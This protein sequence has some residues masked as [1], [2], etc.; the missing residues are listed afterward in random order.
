MPKKTS[1]KDHFGSFT[2]R[3]AK[4]S[5]RVT[6]TFNEVAARVESQGD[7]QPTALD[8]IVAAVEYSWREIAKAVPSERFDTGEIDSWLAFKPWTDFDT[9]RL[10]QVAKYPQGYLESERSP[11]H[12]R[13]LDLDWLGKV[14]P[15]IAAKRDRPIVS[16]QNVGKSTA[17]KLRREGW[18]NA[19]DELLISQIDTIRPYATQIP[20]D[21]IPLKPV[22][23][24]RGTSDIWTR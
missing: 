4:W 23:Q 12:W 11:V 8:M 6:Q 22:N 17:N 3:L 5:S 7:S 21:S 2:R 1:G 16:R 24:T 20:N 19:I 13:Q 10:Y 15:A 18:A 9:F 14:W